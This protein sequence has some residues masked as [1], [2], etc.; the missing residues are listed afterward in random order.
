VLS[1]GTLFYRRVAGLFRHTILDAGHLVQLRRARRCCLMSPN[2]VPAFSAAPLLTAHRGTFKKL[3]LLMGPR[4]LVMP[5][6]ITI[7][8]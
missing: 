2:S 3:R 7:Q 6:L 1:L 5:C 4:A 8:F